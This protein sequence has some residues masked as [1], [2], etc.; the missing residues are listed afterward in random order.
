MSSSIFKVSART[1]II[2]VVFTL[3]GTS[4][5]AYTFSITRDI[6]SKNIEQEKLALVSQTL[7]RETY[8]NNLVKDEITLQPSD[9]LGT[10]EPSHAYRARL[11]GKITAVVL[12]VIAP[13][14]Y[15]GK[16]NLLVAIMSNGEIAGV[17]VA[18]HN[19]TP[20]LGDYIDI[21]KSPWIKI[22]DHTSLEKIRSQDWKVKKDGGTFDYMSGATISPRAVV[23]AVHRALQY[24]KKNRNELLSERS[25]VQEHK[26]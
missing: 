25:N 10:D 16:I 20:G 22:F 14:G 24:F 23:K 2:M 7:P 18:A 19:E 17:R 5:L 15:S 12:E 11:H 26:P 21:A 9:A 1:A 3:I 13:D 4:L 6:I 8:D